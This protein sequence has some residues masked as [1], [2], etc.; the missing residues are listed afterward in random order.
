MVVLHK[1][2]QGR[3]RGTYNRLRWGRYSL[4]QLQ[5]VLVPSGRNSEAAVVEGGIPEGVGM[6]RDILLL[7]LLLLLVVVVVVLGLKG[8]SHG[9]KHC[10]CLGGRCKGRNWLE[11][12]ACWTC[13]M[14]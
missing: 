7:L 4:L 1:E 10:C 14:L 3:V 8:G 13:K 11:V 12:L 5:L 6:V 2:Q 9:E